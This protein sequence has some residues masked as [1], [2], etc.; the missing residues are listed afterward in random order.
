MVIAN[1]QNDFIQDVEISKELLIQ[2]YEAASRQPEGPAAAINKE[3]KLALLPQL[4]AVSN[5]NEVIN[6]QAEP[7]EAASI[8]LAINDLDLADA[9]ARAA[10]IA[11]GKEKVLNLK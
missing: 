6:N 7:N 8:Q 5:M 1:S 3:I 10:L 4:E 9:A 2:V 11:K